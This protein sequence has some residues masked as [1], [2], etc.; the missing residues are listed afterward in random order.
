MS[1]ITRY[2]VMYDDYVV[3]SY[4]TREDA[5]EYLEFFQNQRGW[6]DEEVEEH[7]SIQKEVFI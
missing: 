5:E 3:Q 4:D 1:R 2:N 7:C 6:T